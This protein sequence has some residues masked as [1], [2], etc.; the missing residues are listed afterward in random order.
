MD[1]VF[2]QMV[3]KILES[4]KLSRDELMSR[5]RGKQEELSG[6]VTLEGAANIVARELGI[7]FERKEPEARALHIDDLI[8]GMSKVEM[9]ARVVRIREP[10][11]FQR[12]GGK[13]GQ[14][15]SITLRDKTGEI[16]L[17][18]WDEKSFLIKKGELKKGD[19]VKVQNAYVRQ[20][21]NKQPELSLG[22]RGSVTL[23]PDHPLAKELPPV[24]EAKASIA[25]LTSGMTEV[26][27]SGRVVTTSDLRVF[28]RPDGTT[29]KVSTLILMDRSGQVRVSLWDEWAEFSRNLRRGDALRLENATVRPGLG[30]RVELSLGSSGRLVMNPPDVPEFPELLER[31]LKLSEV[32]ADMRSLELAA[33]VKRI[34][35]PHEFKRSDG[36]TGRVVSVFLADDTGTVRASFWDAAADLAGKL[37]VN[38]VVM[39]RNA[40]TRA[41]LGGRPEVQ[42]GR[43]TKVEV[44]P[45]G[46]GI[47]ELRPRIVEIGKIEPNV[48][49]IEVV[50]RVTEVNEPREFTR[51][52]GSKGKVASMVIADSSGTARV[53]LW[54]EHADKVGGISVGDAVK[55]IDGY[56]TLGLLGQPELH[57]GRHG[58][59]EI[60]PGVE[61]PK[62]EALRAVVRRGARVEISEIEK[63]GMQVQMRGTVVQVFHRRPI[64]DICPNCG[65]S[66]G[67]VDTSLVCEE[68]G[69]VVTPE[70]RVVISLML[71]DGT[72]NI[73]VALFGDIAERLLRM[74]AQQVFEMFRSKPDIAEFY[75]DLKLIGRE[76]IVFG[77]TRR[78]KYFDQIELRGL[79]VQVPDALLEA[80]DILK[81]LKEMA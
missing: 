2:E 50:G 13:P 80:K 51:S 12:S 17:A 33:R 20:G 24:P 9:L 25:D 66:L 7:V 37:N 15:A 53:S 26:D 32:E 5:I 29:G 21:I 62:A 19:V 14:V 57:L 63:E 76:L 28:D 11:E 16:R 58:K 78:D 71:D 67:S 69:K 55:L 65:R 47:G 40:Y 44:N 81:E 54:Q 41:G 43:A 52:D 18:L 22:A 10:R 3:Q 31:P 39:L 1:M 49:S 8:P 77:T 27:V 36:T 48:D 35:P 64:F 74:T 30:D 4:S 59:L 46:V 23:S 60:N 45:L 73:R 6:F 75:R 38:D 68:C 42:V 34:L 56:T 72:G 79:D 61:L 70:H